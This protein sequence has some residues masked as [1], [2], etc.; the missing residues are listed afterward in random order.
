MNEVSDL[1]EPEHDFRKSELINKWDFLTALSNRRLN[2]Q[3]L[4]QNIILGWS[5]DRI[6]IVGKLR[7][8][9]LIERDGQYLTVNFEM[10]MSLSQDGGFVEQKSYNSWQIF[11][12]YH[13]NLAY[14]EV[15]KFQKGHGR[16]DFNP[17]KIDLFVAGGMKTFIHKL[18][19]Q[20]HF[21][22][23]DIACDIINAPND[24][25]NQYRIIAPVSVKAYY[26]RNKELETAY[27]GARSS[28]LQVRMYNKHLE[29]SKKR[30]VIP[31]DVKTWWRVEMQL[32]R[33]K[34]TDW[35][36]MV[37]KNLENFCSPHYF[38]LGLKWTDRVMLTG[39][40]SD[41]NL[42]SGLS[43]NS[44]YKYRNL[45]KLENQND[46]L[47]QAMKQTFLEQSQELKDELDSWLIGLDVTDEDEK[48]H[49]WNDG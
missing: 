2:V 4:G 16:I 33:G 37:N 9:I 24:F 49:H 48:S 45:L 39:L 27:W 10:L 12:K 5:I 11:D 29:Q 1:H 23:A 31:K 42:W 46:E 28:E 17:N 47:T 15:L 22:R 18:F 32:R 3:S 6:T 21:S 13:E 44:K 41:E 34:A 38:P 25:V 14:I 8:S 20:P 40:L 30:Q 43:R 7:Q 36:D 35:H 26:G 19:T